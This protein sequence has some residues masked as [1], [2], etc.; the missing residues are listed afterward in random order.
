M[1]IVLIAG[2]VATPDL[3]LPAVRLLV[4][5]RRLAKRRWRGRAADGVEF[6]FAL[7]APLRPGD[8]FHERVGVRYVVEQEPE[9]VLAIALNALPG[10]AA[11]A[12]GWAVGNLHLELSG[13][14]TRL[15]TPD[16]PAARQLLARLQIDYV[17]TE[18]VF[19][20]GRFKR[21]AGM[22]TAAP[23]LPHELGSSH[24]H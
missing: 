9:P 8:T 10:A 22:V 7:T 2:P 17:V 11:A 24:R 15:L 14:E 1:L 21:S 23:A 19:R 20:P 4:D 3:S 16:E 6:G 18:A 12:V 13:E 5:R